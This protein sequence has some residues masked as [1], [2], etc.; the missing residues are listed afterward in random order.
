MTE[1]ES[2]SAEQLAKDKTMDNVQKENKQF[3]KILPF[4]MTLIFY[5]LINTP[6]L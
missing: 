1:V 3:V 5:M 4:F 2:P 6:I